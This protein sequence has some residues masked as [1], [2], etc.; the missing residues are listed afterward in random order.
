[1]WFSLVRRPFPAPSFT[2]LPI[3]VGVELMFHG[4][5]DVQFDRLIKKKKQTHFSVLLLSY[6]ESQ[7]DHHPTVFRPGFH[8]VLQAD[9]ILN[10]SSS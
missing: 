4:L 7:V 1:M 9:L 3:V 6:L 5:F 8:D 2:Q 10:L